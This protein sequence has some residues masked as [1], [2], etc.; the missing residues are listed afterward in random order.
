MSSWGASSASHSSSSSHSHSG[1]TRTVH[2][3]LTVGADANG[4]Q[5]DASAG[6]FDEEELSA[7][8]AGERG[9]CKGHQSLTAASAMRAIHD[10]SSSWT[11]TTL[12]TKLKAP[13]RQESA[14]AADTAPYIPAACEPL[15]DCSVEELSTDLAE[16]AAPSGEGQEAS[17]AAQAAQGKAA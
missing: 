6:T 10:S 16:A 3:H 14:I 15:A 7:S 4:T 1:A 17:A 11:D 12:P 8:M 5:G 13:S 9:S 2:K